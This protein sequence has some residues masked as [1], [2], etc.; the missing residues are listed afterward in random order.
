MKYMVLKNNI[1]S[2]KIIFGKKNATIV[3]YE[4]GDTTKDFPRSEA[5]DMLVT[6]KNME[7]NILKI[8]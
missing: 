6:C 7:Y 5:W 1:R 3:D 2:L 8:A 4:T